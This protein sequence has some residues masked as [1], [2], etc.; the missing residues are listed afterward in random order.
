MKYLINVSAPPSSQSSLSALRFCRALL[1]QEHELLRVFF[2]GE[3]VYNANS[4]LSP[5]SDE[6]NMEQLWREFAQTHK[7]ELVVCIAA[8]V[9]R[10]LLNE[11]EA[12]RYDKPASNIQAP[13]IVSG[14]GQLVEASVLAD[15]TMTFS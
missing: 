1:K 9:R 12:Q 15:R 5:P 3:G 4:L 14:L 11:E 2:Y 13:F 8:A 6:N 7:V 10:G